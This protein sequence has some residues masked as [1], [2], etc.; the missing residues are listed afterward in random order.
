MFSIFG[1]SFVVGLS[2]A[3]MPGPLLALVISQVIQ[4]G[5]WA[6]PALISGHILAELATVAALTKGLNRFLRRPLIVGIIGLTG[7]SFLLWMAWSVAGTAWQNPTSL[8]TPATVSAGSRASNLLAGFVVSVSNPYWIMWWATV[9]TTYV[10]WSLERQGPR[11]VPVFF[12]GHIL[13]DIVWYIIV[14]AAVAGG[15]RVI[16]DSIYKVL[17]LVCAAALLGLG[18][19]FIVSG[20]RSLS[21]S[22]TEQETK[23]K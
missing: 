15:R 20:V 3:L 14:S 13:S 2:G 9:G 8:A 21:R 17:L 22:K 10:M 5:F 18:I 6:G 19:Y 16:S 12:T 7:G 11:G 1:T 23:G 4:Q